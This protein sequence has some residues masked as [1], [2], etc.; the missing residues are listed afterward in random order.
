MP[1]DRIQQG[2]EN[3]WVRKIRPEIW[4]ARKKKEQKLVKA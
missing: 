4:G 1:T 3:I 2:D